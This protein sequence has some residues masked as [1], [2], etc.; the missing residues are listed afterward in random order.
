[1]NIIDS[2]KRWFVTVTV[3]AII[4]VLLR[5]AVMSVP[6]VHEIRPFSGSSNLFSLTL[7]VSLLQVNVDDVLAERLLPETKISGLRACA[8]SC[9]HYRH[10][11]RS[12]GL[13][14]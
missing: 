3:A 11:C 10:L 14:Y 8:K 12:T 4:Q 2:S 6:L 13:R 1:M 5:P 9:S 7:I